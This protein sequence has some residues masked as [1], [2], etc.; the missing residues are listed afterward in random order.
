MRGS[1]LL[2]AILMA[3]AIACGPDR[4]AQLRTEI[5]GLKEARMER[6]AVGKAQEEAK[7]AEAAAGERSAELQK[8]QAQL[9]ERE[10]E[11]ERLQSAFDA[12]VKR[13]A[14][15]RAAVDAEQVQIQE[16]AEAAAR[17]ERQVAEVTARA[18]WAHDQAEQLAK[19]LALDDPGWAA[20]RRLR[21]LD[22]FLAGLAR[23][24]PDDALLSD[25]ALAMKPVAAAA[26]TSPDTRARAAEIASRVRDHFASVYGLE[27]KAAPAPKQP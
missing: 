7:A 18:Q 26:A 4:A 23:E 15:L 21:A 5:A 17:L 8:A 12:E 1:F 2:A 20:Q 10:A 27:A 22:E 11:A 13:N 3:G 25:L 9:A 16:K 24:Y 6:S 14:E 19:Q